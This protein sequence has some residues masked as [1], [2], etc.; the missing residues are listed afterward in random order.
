VVGPTRPT[1]KLT[2]IALADRHNPRLPSPAK[3]R[4]TPSR[5][6]YYTFRRFL[7]ATKIQWNRIAEEHNE[8]M[9]LAPLSNPQT[10]PGP[11]LS[12]SRV[13]E[14]LFLDLHFY[15]ICWDKMDKY[16]RRFSQL[17]NDMD[18]ARILVELA[19]LL[20]DAVS[21]RDHFEHWDKLLMPPDL[22]PLGY[23]FAVVGMGDSA[24]FTVSYD[25]RGKGGVKRLKSVALG[26]KELAHVIEVG[27]RI[28]D[29]LEAAP[30]F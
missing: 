14:L 4:S 13:S 6:A 12:F 22:G 21:A 29:H 18:I 3:F 15:L 9:R 16:L 11:A 20:S 2:P 26:R 24:T 23:G 27:E 19:P 30:D 10:N 7:E 1:S 28:I 8:M 5:T 25:E 17:Q